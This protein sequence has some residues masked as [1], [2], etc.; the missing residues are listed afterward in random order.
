M[1][2]LE[3]AYLAGLFDGEGCVQ[4]AHHK[5]QRNK[6]TEQHTLRCAVNM[7]DE[8]SVKSFLVFGGS[9]CQKTRDIINPKWQNQWTWSVSSNQA[10]RFLEILLPYLRLKQEQAKLAIEFQRFRSV[11]YNPFGQRAK[12]PP[13][14][15]EQRNWYWQKLKELKR[16]H[17]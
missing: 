13:E 4:I 7:T 12:I 16:I 15:I 9:I 2:D 10:L 3:L 5:P 17:R 14:E 1:K 6:R 8:V 11:K